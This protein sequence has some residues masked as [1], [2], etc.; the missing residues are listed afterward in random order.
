MDPEEMLRSLELE[1]GRGL[2]LIEAA[3][4]LEELEAAQVEVMGRRSPFSAVQKS[5]G[6]LSPDDRKRVGQEANEVRGHLQGATRRP[7]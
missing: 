7:S 1:R 5:L 2:D 6:A 3:A 4:T